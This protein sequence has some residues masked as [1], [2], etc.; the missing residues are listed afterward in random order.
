MPKYRG[1]NY[2]LDTRPGSGG[3]FDYFVTVF[4]AGV[5]ATGTK[6]LTEAAARAAGKE[7]AERYL[8]SLLKAPEAD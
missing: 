3:C 1:Q 4:P 8:D 2:T 7:S 5:I 6:F